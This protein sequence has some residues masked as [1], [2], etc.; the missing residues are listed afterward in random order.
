MAHNLC[1]SR[2]FFQN[3]DKIAGQAHQRSFAIK[4]RSSA[5]FKKKTS[6]PQALL[7][8]PAAC[9]ALAPS[10]SDPLQSCRAGEADQS[11]KSTAAL[12][13]I[14]KPIVSVWSMGRGGVS[15]R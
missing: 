15:F 3:G 13:K 5:L 9:M 8:L 7:C 11:F 6:V 14:C 12:L 2:V 4:K 1:V 10:G